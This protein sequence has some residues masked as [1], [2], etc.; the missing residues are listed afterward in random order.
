M[1]V[2]KR[3]RSLSL[4]PVPASDHR[5]TL[6]GPSKVVHPHGSAIVGA[7]LAGDGPETDEEDYKLA[8]SLDSEDWVRRRAGSA[9]PGC[10][11]ESCISCAGRYA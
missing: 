5:S 2:N 9:S 11:I 7:H 4:S 6:A 1:S 8:G 10:I 3:S